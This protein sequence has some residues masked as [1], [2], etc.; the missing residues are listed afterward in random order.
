VPLWISQPPTS[1][2]L[3]VSEH[4]EAV[5]NQE[6]IQQVLKIEKE[7]QAIRDSA[8]REAEQLPLQADTEA[9]ALL[10]QARTDAQEKA[11]EL[12]ANAKAND[13]SEDILAQADAEATRTEAVAMN[14]FDRA[15]G[16]VLDRVLGRE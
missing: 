4:R 3:R 16:Y 8:A 11:H 13:E 6:L 12:I 10:E 1:I 5:L 2:A 9:R 7:A 15:V 14:H